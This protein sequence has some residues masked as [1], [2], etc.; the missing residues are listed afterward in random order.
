MYQMQFRLG[1][2]PRPRWGSL[3]RFQTPSCI[4][5]LRG[6]TSKGRGGDET[7]DETP[8]LHAPQVIFLDTP[9]IVISHWLAVSP[10]QQCST[11]VRHCDNVGLTN[12]V[13]QYKF[14]N[15]NRGVKFLDKHKNAS[16][17]KLQLRLSSIQKL[18]DCTVLRWRG[19]C[20]RPS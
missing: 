1:L 3:Q 10:L 19:L 9:K 12:T 7:K 8:P 5:A 18:Y 13:A 4:E 16:P 11:A 17:E 14:H 6:P 15:Y 20:C 2:C